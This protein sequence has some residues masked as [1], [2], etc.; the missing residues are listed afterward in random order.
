MGLQHLHAAD[1]AKVPG[2]LPQHLGGY[3]L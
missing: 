2:H 3:K 1:A